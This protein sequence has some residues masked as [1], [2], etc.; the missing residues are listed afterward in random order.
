MNLTECLLFASVLV[1]AFNFL[2]V[3]FLSNAMFRF[4]VGERASSRDPVLPVRG[5]SEGGE[6]LVDIKVVDTYDPRFKP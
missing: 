5:N 4:I 2:A 6:G 3:I 1:S